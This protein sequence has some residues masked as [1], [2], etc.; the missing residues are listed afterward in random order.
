MRW[1]TGPRV[2]LLTMPWLYFI[3]LRNFIY[4]HC[5]MASFCILYLLFTLD[6]NP[7]HLCN[8]QYLCNHLFCLSFVRFNVFESVAP[9]WQ[10]SVLDLLSYNCPPSWLDSSHSASP[11]T[12]E[13]KTSYRPRT[14]HCRLPGVKEQSSMMI[15]EPILWTW[16][17]EGNQNDVGCKRALLICDS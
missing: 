17:W 8:T 16:E 11:Y 15:I 5:S 9:L 13:E 14:V 3:D 12:T 1:W 10:T 6:C 7:R 2:T 4:K